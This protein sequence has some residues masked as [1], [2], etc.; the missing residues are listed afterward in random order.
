MFQI[1]GQ[2]H[3]SLGAQTRRR[4]TL[5]AYRWFQVRRIFSAKNVQYDVKIIEPFGTKGAPYCPANGSL[6][7]SRQGRRPL[8]IHQVRNNDVSIFGSPTS[9][10]VAELM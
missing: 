6:T 5:S 2:I 1:A 4:A 10:P 3:L 8:E 7:S 9:R